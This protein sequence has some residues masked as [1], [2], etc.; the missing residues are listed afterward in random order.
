M[1]KTECEIKNGSASAEPLASINDF[2][3]RQ[4]TATQKRLAFLSDR[5]DLDSGQIRSTPAENCLISQDQ[6]SLGEP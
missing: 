6:Q 3:V 5:P 4:H 1:R 2:D